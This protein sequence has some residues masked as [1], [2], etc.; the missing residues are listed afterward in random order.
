M[1]KEL[2]SLKGTK[3]GLVLAIAPDSDFAAV[4]ASLKAKLVP[5]KEFWEGAAVT[6]DNVPS[7]WTDRERE[8][9]LS[10]LTEFNM[11]LK[12]AYYSAERRS[13]PK[14]SLSEAPMQRTGNNALVLKRNLRSGQRVFHDGNLVVVG[15]VN[16][17]AEVV[18]TGDIIIL[19]TLRGMAH[20]G[21]GGNTKASVMALRLQ[22]MQLRIADYISRCPDEPTVPPTFP[23]VALI[24]DDQIA[25]QEYVPQ[26]LL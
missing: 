16:P 9:L 17:G 8:Q 7:G 5:A 25:V 13:Q 15:D 18:A 1:G 4:L 11:V 6:I 14:T 19:G 12:V 23:E 26:L 24:K 20:A 22:P 2:V 21:A 10:L 3:E